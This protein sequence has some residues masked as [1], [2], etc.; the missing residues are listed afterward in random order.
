M[1][2][3][4]I[5]YIFYVSFEL[6]FFFNF[7]VGSFQHELKKRTEVTSGQDEGVGR[8]TLP[9]PMTKR[10]T[11]THLKTK[12]NQNCQNIEL[13]ESPTTKELKKKHSFR[14]SEGWRW[15]AA[16]QRTHGKAVVG[17]PSGQS[18]SWWAGWSHICVRINC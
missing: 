15:A 3:C 7:N 16:A 11:T 18:G 2:M 10:R 6:K 14:L 4:G 9:L 8:Y 17:G 12:N 5:Y 1:G 13:Y